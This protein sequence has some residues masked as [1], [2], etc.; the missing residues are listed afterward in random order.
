[1]RRLPH[2]GLPLVRGVRRRRGELVGDYAELLE[3]QADHA[4][5]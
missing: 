1:V 5:F 3:P 4:E 2:A